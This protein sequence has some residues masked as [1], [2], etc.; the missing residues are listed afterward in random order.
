MENGVTEKL[1]SG[2]RRT[3]QREEGCGKKIH[4]ENED[5]VQPQDDVVR[6]SETPEREG[7]IVDGEIKTGKGDQEKMEDDDENPKKNK[8]MDGNVP[9]G[10][11]NGFPGGSERDQQRVKGGDVNT[12]GEDGGERKTVVDDAR[13]EVEEEEALMEEL[14]TAVGLG[15]WQVPLILTALIS[16]YAN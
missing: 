1:S 2:G 15:R 8:T 11:K 13:T 16:K 3:Q 7:N 4:D 10:C 9:R 6:T 5:M 14:L 12:G